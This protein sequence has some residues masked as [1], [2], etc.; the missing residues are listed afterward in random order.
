MGVSCY[1]SR[2]SR[3]IIDRLSKGNWFIDPSILDRM[4]TDRAGDGR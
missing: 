1:I 2:F 4:P 3:S